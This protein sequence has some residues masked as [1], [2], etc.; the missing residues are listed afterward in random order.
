MK[1]PNRTL[2]IFTLSALDVL[3]MATGTF[4]LIVVLL[5]P[6][7]RKSFDA[8]AEIKDV[9]AAT[10][11]MTAEAEA[12]E[13]A[14]ALDF[15]AASK[16]RAEAA[17]LQR[18]ARELQGTASDQSDRAQAAQE[19][20]ARQRRR[21]DEMQKLAEQRVIQELDL[22]FLVD[23]TRSMKP[24]LKELA[25]SMNSIVQILE[26]L[27]P[28][29]RIGFV[30]YRDRDAGVQPLIILPLTA[31]DPDLQRV[32]K[33]VAGLKISP[34][35]SPSR[36][37]DLYLGLTRALSMRF[38]WDA[39]HSI[40]VIGDA[41]AHRNEQ[42]RALQ[43]TRLFASSGARNSLSALFVTTPSSLSAGNVDRGFFEVLA[44]AGR[45]EFSDHSG[46]LIESVLL[47][48]LI[49]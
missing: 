34:R 29:V 15:S 10:D 45:G 32:L 47:S 37:E 7:Y 46:R 1:R 14:A 3:A 28:S 26:R 17:Q 35:A 43:R 19:E 21:I 31:T 2:S 11:V 33:F 27:V 25:R 20:T 24:V 9:R 13:R 8:T 16:V 41:A 40:I 23:T 4:V 38:R 5:M 44:E 12:L 48:V 49:D 36:E 39:K 42:S 22:I 6:Y 30:A 18:A